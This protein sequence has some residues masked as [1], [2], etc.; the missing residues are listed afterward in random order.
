MVASDAAARNAGLNNRPAATVLPGPSQNLQRRPARIAEISLALRPVDFYRSRSG[1]M[2]MNTTP[3][4]ARAGD[5][6]T[7][8]DVA[9][10][11]HSALVWRASQPPSS[12]HP[13]PNFD[14]RTPD[15]RKARTIRVH[16][17]GS[18]NATDSEDFAAWTR[19]YDTV[20]RPNVAHHPA[21]ATQATGRNHS[22]GKMRPE[23]SR[24]GQ[25]HAGTRLQQAV[26]Q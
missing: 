9:V 5:W 21:I 22:K 13:S 6:T 20:F 2:L 11:N 17:A 16:R 18:R 7:T 24:T 25:Q 14:C 3:A 15:T 19:R 10:S 26:D 8:S 23:T 1:S 12:F 4:T